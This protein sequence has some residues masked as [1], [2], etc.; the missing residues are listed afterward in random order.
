MTRSL[1]AL[2]TIRSVPAPPLSDQFDL[3]GGK[4]GCVDRI[5]ARRT[6]DSEC[7]VG[8]FGMRDQHLARQ[9]I[10]G[11]RAAVAGD[12]L[13][14]SL[15]AVPLTITLVGCTVAIAGYAAGRDRYIW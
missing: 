12:T 10:H 2:P 6:I 8:A 13:I 15:P 9:P 1:P 3:A 11:D 5:V 7:V 4:S 14:A